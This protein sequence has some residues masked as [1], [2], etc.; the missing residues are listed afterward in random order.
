[1]CY[2]KQMIM[3]NTTYS[4]ERFTKDGKAMHT[5]N[6]DVITGLPFGR[7]APEG[8][9][10]RCDELRNGAEVRKPAFVENIERRKKQEAQRSEEIRNHFAVGGKGWLM[11]KAGE[12]D[13]TFDW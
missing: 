5:C 7:K 10:R 1:M 12:V 6:G 11:A 8:K 3:C 13:T 4:T 2:Q 9:C